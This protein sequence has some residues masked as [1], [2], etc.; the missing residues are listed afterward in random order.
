MKKLLKVTI[1]FLSSLLFTQCDDS[2]L[3]T[4]PQDQL[5]SELFW[6]TEADAVNAV[7]ALYTKLPGISEM[8][9]DMMSDIGH[10]NTTYDAKVTI[11]RGE[12][13]ATL[14]YFDNLWD[15]GYAAIRAA[16]YFLEN[17]DKVK[18]NEP[19]IDED[20]LNRLKGEARFIRAFFYTRMVFLFGD[21]PLVTKTLDVSEGK[22]IGKN[23]SEEIWDFV[24]KEFSEIANWLPEAYSGENLGRITKGAAWAMKARAMLYAKRYTK[25][26]EAAKSVMDL[27]V[28]GLYPEY[29]N[30]FS[31]DAQNNT[32]VILDRQY[33]QDIANHNFFAA[34]APKGMQGGVGVCPTLTLVDA[35]QTIN[36]LA[37]DEDPLYDPLDPYANRDPR[38]GYSLFIPTFSDNV[39]GDELYN[40]IIYDPRPGSGTE[41]EVEVDYFRTKTGFNTKKYINRE[42]KDDRGNGGTNFILIRYADVLLMYAEAKIEAN[43]IDASVYAA[44]NAVR[45]RN[46]VNLPEVSAGKSQ[47]ELRQ[48]LRHER[49]VELALEG[50]RFFDIRRWKIAH[51]VMQGPI[52]GMRYIKSGETEVQTLR[53]G[54]VE[55]SFNPEKDYLFPVPQEE[56]L[57]N[58]NL[59]PQNPNY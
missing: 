1:V 28:Y 44:I 58:E 31:Y 11:E 51:V 33:A 55:R 41:D 36:G 26:A 22:T 3:D 10:T 45:Q 2:L 17:I 7:N 20:L 15:N 53:Y 16:N 50:L 18:E 42:D 30:L 23:S 47:E 37:I 27:N 40:G 35:Y 52:E 13:N 32:E 14:G 57:L 54:G 5:G 25:A 59:K 38:L 46:D 29:E 24:E 9:W 6:K 48:I 21:I 34:Y 19:D 12:H 39:P 43:Q 4:Y 49:M 8:Q 56:I